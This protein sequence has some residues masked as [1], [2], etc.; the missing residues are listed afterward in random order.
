M[1]ENENLEE[2]NK[3][4][5]LKLYST[6]AIYATTFFAGPLAFGYMM[7]KN[8]KE[9][10]NNRKANLVLI[11]VP[12]FIVL[13]FGS[14]FLLPENFIDRIPNYLFPALMGGVAFGFSE[15]YFGKILN[16]HKN[17]GNAFYSVGNIIGVGVLS[18]LPFVLMGVFFFMS[19]NLLFDNG[20][21]KFMENEEETLE[22]YSHLNTKSEQE[23]LNELDIIIPKWEENKEIIN[24]II[25]EESGNQDT[26]LKNQL[27][28]E[29]SELRIKAFKLFKK[30]ISEDTNRY[31]PELDRIHED[32]DQ[33]LNK[34][35][36]IE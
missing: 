19:Q 3:T 25:K 5:N 17:K 24:N 34:L 32:I 16:E 9:L 13:F 1:M 15:K 14:L 6:K 21:S 36:A 4:I 7:W 30:S 12:I 33:V 8:F 20:M 10:G 2:I 26:E 27:L 35:D 18:V 23:L 22:F 11:L 29:Y 28:V 31:Y